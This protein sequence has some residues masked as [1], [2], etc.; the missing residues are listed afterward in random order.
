LRLTQTDVDSSEIERVINPLTDVF[1]NAEILVVIDESGYRQILG[2][3]LGLFKNFRH[4]KT[5]KIYSPD[6]NI[7]VLLQEFLPRMTSLTEIYI[8]SKA[9]RVEGRFNTIRVNVPELKKL[10]VDP[11]YVEQAKAFFGTEVNVYEIQ[12]LSD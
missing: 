1:L 8:D 9:P 11:E 5:L 4:I 6:R 7:N 2:I 10:W 12:R 3:F